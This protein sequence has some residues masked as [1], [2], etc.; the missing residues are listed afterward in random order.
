MKEEVQNL[1]LKCNRIIYETY[2]LSDYNIS[3]QPTV[4]VLRTEYRKDLQSQLY[5]DSKNTRDSAM[6]V[7]IYPASAGDLEVHVL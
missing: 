5:R 2:D 6:E 4:S 1:R 3:L 7:T